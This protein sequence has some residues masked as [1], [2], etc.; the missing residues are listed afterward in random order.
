MH[1]ITHYN[2]RH[3]HTHRLLQVTNDLQQTGAQPALYIRQLYER[4]YIDNNRKDLI[5]NVAIVLI[6]YN[7]MISTVLHL[8]VVK[9][10]EACLA[11]FNTLHIYD[12]WSTYVNI[13][14]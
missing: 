11:Y 7:E 10:I 4:E 3:F 9:Y 1:V 5:K 13:I 8:A 12:V 14:L 2:T 6:Q